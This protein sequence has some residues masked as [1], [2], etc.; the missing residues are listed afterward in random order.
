MLYG[1]LAAASALLLTA[2]L[3]AAVRVPALRLGI[4]ERRRGRR[5][6]LLGG[7]AV[8]AGVGV[9][10]WVGERSGVAPLGGEAG[11]LIVV[12]AG[13]GVLGLV[14][15]VWRLPAV[16]GA[17][18]VVVAAALVVPYRDLGVLG[19][20]SGVLWIVLVVHGFKGMTRSDGALGVVG[21][22]TAFALSGCAAAE[23]MD[24]LA[25]L[26]SVLAA[27]LTGF[28]MHNWP[29]ARVVLGTCG[30]LFVGFVLAGGVLHVYA[31]G[32]GAGYGVGVGAP[33]ALTAVATADVLLVLVSRKRAGRELWRG[34]P[35]HLAHRLRRIGLTP[36]GVVVVL[37][38]AA[39]G[40]AGVGFAIHMLWTEPRSALW[41]AGA[42]GVVVL[43]MLF[44]PVGG[45]RPAPASAR[46]A[47]RSIPAATTRS[48]AP[49]AARAVPAGVHRAPDPRP[50]PIP[51]G[52]APGPASRPQRIRQ[53]ETAELGRRGWVG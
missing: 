53:Q 15:D 37:G 1:I 29:P 33:F 7:V 36:P 49:T 20:V 8:M 51:G 45:A 16:V 42:A 10:A 30:A 2:L 52:R 4:V 38:I 34:G 31:V 43:G 48:P 35:D 25:T 32:Y 22:V 24:G 28:L 26:F 41:V 21:A 13:L 14:G 9:V 39:A 3:S 6:P 11:W 12:G 18:G 44:V 23:V 46:P 19:G 40:S 50:R 5:V 17:A 27:A 47:T